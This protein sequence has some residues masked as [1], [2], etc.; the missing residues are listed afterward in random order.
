MK[1]E[2]SLRGLL[3]QINGHEELNLP[4]KTTFILLL[5][6]LI[7]N[8]MFGQVKLRI[9]GKVIS[10]MDHKPMQGATIKQSKSIAVAQTDQN[11]NFSLIITETSGKLIVSYIG[12]KTVEI[13]FNA[14]NKGPFLIELEPNQ[15]NLD[16]VTI[17]TGFQTLPKERSTGSF[18]ITRCVL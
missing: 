7:T 13:Q 17:S 16:L 14:V 4:L 3:C 15:N 12:Y 2:N 5:L 10:A 8:V 11:G 6:S 9:T 18:F 1:A